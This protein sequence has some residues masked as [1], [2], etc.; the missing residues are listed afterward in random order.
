MATFKSTTFGK[1]SGKYGEA[2]ATKSKT[3]GKNYLRVASVPSNPRTPKQVEHRGKFG[4]INR[5][6]RSFYPVFKVTFGGNAGIRLGI[7]IAFKNAILGEYPDF[8]LDYTQLL[9]TDGGLYQTGSVTALKAGANS[10]KIDW[11][12]SDM[13][14]NNSTDLTNLIF[15]NEDTDQAILKQTL[16]TREAATQTVELPAIW[17]GGKIHCWMYFTA[18]NGVT[19]SIS[20]Y[21]D[22]IQL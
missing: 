2:L 3:T 13:A 16:V 5:V 18:P 4:Y 12:Y 15:Y 20:Q 21:I 10:V 11:D 17:T 22:M 1:I 14:G 6:M 9:F 7:N 19:N 8:L